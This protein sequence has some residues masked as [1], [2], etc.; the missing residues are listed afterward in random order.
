MSYFFI[1]IFIIFNLKTFSL[2]MIFNLHASVNININS[3]NDNLL[4]F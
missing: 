1:L 3:Q 4:H 2:K